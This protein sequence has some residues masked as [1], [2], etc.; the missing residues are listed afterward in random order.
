MHNKV[1]SCLL[2]SPE[3]KPFMCSNDFALNQSHRNWSVRSR[4]NAVC[5]VVASDPDVSVW[6]FNDVVGNWVYRVHKNEIT[7]HP[8]DAFTHALRRIS[9]FCSNNDVSELAVFTVFVH[10]VHVHEISLVAQSW[11]HALADRLG[12]LENVVMKH[13]QAAGY[14]YSV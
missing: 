3:I 12:D 10:F 9:G 14:S 13:M 2:N 8:G 4:I 6:D 11:Q 7:R 5:K 1:V